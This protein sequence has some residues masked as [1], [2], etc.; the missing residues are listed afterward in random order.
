MNRV[1]GT[2]AARWVIPNTEIVLERVATGHRSGEF[3][4]SSE[5]VARADEFYQRVRG[6][7]YSSSSAKHE[8][9]RRPPVSE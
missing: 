3:L 2:N 9:F 5:T 8:P 4:F 1:T 6:L 7:S